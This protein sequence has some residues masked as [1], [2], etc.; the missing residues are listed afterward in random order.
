MKSLLR[1]TSETILVIC[2]TNHALDQFLEDIRNVGVSDDDMLRL[3]SKSTAATKHLSLFEQS[4]SYRRK[5]QS[6]DLLHT[7]EARV[8]NI[9]PSIE[10]KAAT[11]RRLKISRKDILEFLQF[12]ETD[13][14]FYPALCPP[15]DDNGGMITIGKGGKAIGPSYLIDRWVDG[16]DAGIFKKSIGNEHREIWK[17]S[18]TARIESFRRWTRD[19]YLEQAT[20]LQDSIQD[21]QNA[22]EKLNA[23][24]DE[25][26]AD[27]VKR[28]RIIGCTTSAAAKYRGLL[29]NA[30]PGL[31]LVE[32]AG[33]ILETHILTSLCA[34]TKHLVLIGDHQQLRPKVNNFDLTIEK[35]EGYDLNMSLFER[36][37]VTGYPHTSLIKQHRMRPEISVLVRRLMYPDLEDDAKTSDRPNIRGLQSNIIFVNHEHPEVDFNSVSDRRDEGSKNSR[38]NVFEAEMVLRTVRYL[39]QQGYGSDKQVVLTPYL[40][41][42]RLLH[43]HLSD[44]HDPVLNDLD[45]FDLV[46][47]G[48]IHSANTDAGKSKLRIS[49]IGMIVFVQPLISSF[50]FQER[51]VGSFGALLIEYE[52]SRQLPRRGK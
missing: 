30:N 39:A 15:E 44:E 23:V 21:Y 17:M 49:T 38:Q 43:Q 42:L 9:C 11:F 13:S 10:R 51:N 27:V 22:F 28:K 37:V 20:M 32:E 31:V 7:Y 2:Y 25:K 24:R 18:K 3:G 48:L 46:R 41:Q 6:W 16:L 14:D 19:F 1:N 8:D 45:S 50:K 35:G 33:E 52:C 5:A 12:S 40:G 26:F 29:T 47:A 4:Q 34:N 36:L